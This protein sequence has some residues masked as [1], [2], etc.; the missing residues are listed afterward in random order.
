[1]LLGECEG[2]VETDPT[3][4]DWWQESVSR[5]RGLRGAPQGTSGSFRRRERPSQN[6][7]ELRVGLDFG[8]GTQ[9]ARTLIEGS[10]LSA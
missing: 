5:V 2:T 3:E 7:C 4:G 1:M 9:S 10:G 6:E 8:A